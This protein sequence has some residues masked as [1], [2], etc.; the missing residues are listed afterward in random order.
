VSFGYAANRDSTK[1]EASTF[2]GYAAG[3]GATAGWGYSLGDTVIGA[4]AGMFLGANATSCWNVIIGFK[5]GNYTNGAAPLTAAV[6]NV[7]I[8]TCIMCIGGTNNIIFGTCANKSGIASNTTLIWNV[9]NGVGHS[10]VRLCGCLVKGGGSF[11]IVHPN[12]A[13]SKDKVLYHSFVESPSR[14]DNLYRW[15]VDVKDRSHS[16]KLPNY[17][18]HLNENTTIKI[19]SVGHFGKAYGQIDKDQDNLTICTNQD[20]KYNVLAVAT[21]CDKHALA[22]NFILEKDMNE[23]DLM[24][25]GVK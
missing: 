12:P 2:V 7:I 23:R 17:Y 9:E 24:E 13:K 11:E 6:S 19:S 22:D 14:G 3:C 16:I 15:S 25:F 1:I 10:G 4:C 5:S 8:G 21:R 20:G 18:K